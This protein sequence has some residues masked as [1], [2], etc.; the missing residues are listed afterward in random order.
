[1]GRIAMTA[2]A[3][4]AQPSIDKR[5]SQQVR[6]D[7][8]IFT[9]FIAAGFI[10]SVN[11]DVVGLLYGWATDF[12]AMQMSKLLGTIIVACVG[13]TLYILTRYHTHIRDLRARLQAEERARRV[14]MHD[15]LTG[16][17]NR[18]HLKGVLNWL[19]SENNGGERLAVVML[20]LDKFAAFNDAHGR[21]VGDEV[22][23]Q[24]GKVLN[25]RAGVDGFV[26][27]LESDEF[28][29]LLP[30]KA[31][32]ELM[33]WLSATLTAIEAP[34]ETGD[35]TVTISATAGAAVGLVDGRDA[36]TLLHRSSLALRRA[37]D[38][39]RGWFAFFKT[40]MDELVRQR[41]MFE[42]DLWTAVREDQI[43]P[44]FQPL[45]SLQDGRVRGYEILARW[46]H[47]TRGPIP[48][49]QFIP[50]AEASGAICD[51]TFNLLRKACKEAAGLD[52]ALHLSLN[53][54]PVQLEEPEFAQ[55][56]LK[57]LEDA[58]FDPSR[59]EIELT[60]AALVTD[61]AAARDVVDALQAK[62]VRVA[63]DNFGTGHASLT[64]LRQLPF[65]ML[66]IDRS[67]VRAMST[68]AEAAIMV[69]TI[70]SMAKSLSLTVVA[71]GVETAEQARALAGLG[72]DMAQGYYFGRAAAVAE[73]RRKA[74]AA[75]AGAVDEATATPAAD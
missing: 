27:R 13:L 2:A 24:V 64:Q 35:K 56:L 32:E 10:L 41:A 70:I 25:L 33:D 60:E 59:L 49:D 47:P 7:L 36:E 26:A 5:V 46:T 14:A 52:S 9:G 45:V 44:H 12:Q 37:K 53:V 29:V 42:S 54:S 73:A 62:G 19:L 16:L 68:D 11:L 40:G 31:E 48:P 43:A 4:K 38:A 58:A 1:M 50:A 17:P 55:K 6:R 61:L 65:D 72:C 74:A 15:Q 30:N 71:E 3:T 8:M 39:N 21:A 63:L 66:K 67:F 23:I 34:L 51:L 22:M 18:R 75:K 28:V 20:N 69:R 57:V